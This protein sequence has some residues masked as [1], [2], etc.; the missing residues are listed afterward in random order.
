MELEQQCQRFD[1]AIRDNTH[2]CEQWTAKLQSL[3]THEIDEE[4]DEEDESE[5][6]IA[7]AAE[8]AAAM[9]LKELSAEEIQDLDVVQLKSEVAI[10]EGLFSVFAAIKSADQCVERVEKARP[11]LAVL[12]EYRKREQE[13]LQRA[14]DL[15]AV[16]AERDGAKAQYEALRKQRLEEFMEG[17]SQISLKLK[18]MYQVIVQ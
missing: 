2:K 6:A 12:K 16:T 18:E 3:E 8:R 13:F 5:A 1:S 9:E 10:L 17:F 15:E 7:A 11:N 4:D 14:K